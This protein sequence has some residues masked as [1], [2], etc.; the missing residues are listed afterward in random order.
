MY[1][2]KLTLP[3]RSLA[4]R[5]LLITS[6]GSGKDAA[7]Q[8]PPWKGPGSQLS[9]TPKPHLKN[10]AALGTL[11]CLRGAG[12]GSSNH[13]RFTLKKPQNVMLALHVGSLNLP[14]RLQHALCLPSPLSQTAAA[15]RLETRKHFPLQGCARRGKAA[16]GGAEPVP[17]AGRFALQV[18][19]LPI[20]SGGCCWTGEEHGVLQV[21]LL[22]LAQLQRRAQGHPAAGNAPTE[23]PEGH[24]PAGAWGRRM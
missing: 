22:R 10:R 19:A 8:S 24:H 11:S 13:A 2:G 15:Q 4:R 14:E 7:E 6:F 1:R 18:G 20:C 21:S 17:A 5:S 12:R 23:P 9:P 3:A 16:G